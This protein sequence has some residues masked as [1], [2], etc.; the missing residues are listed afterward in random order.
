MDARC[1]RCLYRPR[2]CHLRD[3]SGAQQ[4][5]P[6]HPAV[7]GVGLD[8]QAKTAPAQSTRGE[9]APRGL[10]IA[11][12]TAPATPPPPQRPQ[13]SA[14]PHVSPVPQ[15]PPPTAQPPLPPPG[16]ALLLR[17]QGPMTTPGEPGARKGSESLFGSTV[18][19]PTLSPGGPISKGR[20]KQLLTRPSKQPRPED[21]GRLSRLE[22]LDAFATRGSQPTPAVGISLRS[23]SDG[24][25]QQHPSMHTF[26]PAPWT[27][28]QRT[29]GHASAA[30][31]L[32][33]V[34]DNEQL[35]AF[36]FPRW[37]PPARS[38]RNLPP[39]WRHMKQR[40]V[41]ASTGAGGQ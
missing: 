24:A 3:S 31:E 37:I 30:A 34:V 1:L 32:F 7:K 40:V 4:G 39:R 9:A 41:Y 17:Q 33:Y 23:A 22:N 16:L 25:F 19:S 2:R 20:L 21:R 15:M 12:S 14:H 35:L 8:G 28:Q 5:P 38:S 18:E 26:S 10:T 6:S 27:E 29:P 36:H 11:M 13:G